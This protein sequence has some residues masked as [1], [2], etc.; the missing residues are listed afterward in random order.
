MHLNGVVSVM[1][2]ILFRCRLLLAMLPAL[3]LCS[4]AG[5]AAGSGETLYNGIALPREWPP[6]LSEFPT[7][8]E[9]EPVVPPYLTSPPG[10]ITID[11]GRQLFVD[12]F[13]IADT[14]LK[15]TFH[16]PKY[17]SASPVLKPD[18]PW[19]M[20]NPDHAAAMVFSDG[21]WFDPKDQLFKMWYMAGQ[22]EATAYATSRDGIK[23]EKPQLDV[24]PGTN[25]VQPGGR[26]SSTVWLDLEEKDPSRRFKMFRVVGAGEDALSK[27]NNWAMEIH[28]SAD[29]IHWGEPVAT[30]GRVVD[31]STVFWNPFRKVWVYSIRHVYATGSDADKSYGF[32]RR[33][34]YHEGPDVLAAAKWEVNEPLRW[35]DVDRLDPQ[36]EDLKI[37]PQLYNL[38]AVAYESLMVGFFTVW[39]GQP[40]DRHKPN[41]VV[42]GYSRDGWHWSRPDRRAFCPVSDKQGDWN[43]NNVQSAG[44]GFLVVGDE[45][46]F[47]VSGRSGRP[48]NNKAGDLTT[49]LAKLRRDGFASMD[50]EESGGVLTTRP[51]RFAG[52]HLFVNVDDPNGEMRVEILNADGQP[53][54]PFTAGNCVPVTADK[55]LQRVEWKA[56]EDLTSLS[57]QP[58]RFRFHLKNGRLYAF[59]V[60]PEKSGASQGYLAAG[61]PGFSS[62]R[63]T[64]KLSGNED[65]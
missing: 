2:T 54:L 64:G 38:D 21:V 23:W 48:G 11:V 55:T 15:R 50:A 37:K 1:R 18:K 9:R 17:H 43:A 51:L 65:R 35:T 62:H 53:A 61:G 57:N 46:Y 60:S 16:L 20:E 52:K 5:E 12:D 42:L 59:W 26:D 30:S 34:S 32:A 41:N 39:R 44:G 4:A 29:G 49:G 7:S 14:N 40:A 24:R 27:W 6:R 3:L 8:V 28:F 25:I 47:Y 45:L 13:L 31:R 19:E 22:S 36:R 58:V 56:A 63:D 10:V 33:R